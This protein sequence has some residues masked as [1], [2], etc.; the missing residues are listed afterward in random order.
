MSDGS[1]TMTD[2]DQLGRRARSRAT[3]RRCAVAGAADATALEAVFH[4]QRR[5][6]A[7]PV[8]AGEPAGI[9]ALLGTL[10]FADEPHTI[11]A[12]PATGNPAATAVELVRAGRADFVLK[13]RLATRDLLRPV[14]DRTSG[15]N[16]H[17]FVTHL[18][19][20]RLA[21]YHKL[22]A[23]SDSAVIPHPTLADK[24]RIVAV[25]VAALRRLGLR[26]PVVGVL[27]AV[28]TVSERMPETVHADQLRRAGERG[29]FGDAVV[30]GPISYDLA[31]SR[32]SAVTK[33][34]DA[35]HAGDVDMLLVPEMVTGNV[36]SKIWNADPANLLAGCLV[37]TRAPVALTSR[38]APLAEKLH[39]ILLCSLLS[40]PTP[41][42][43]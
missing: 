37:G 34:Y 11:V 25:C 22:L 20:M 1:R 26:R 33:G 15:L 2:F 28:E 24:H 31:T 14:L 4:A 17:G 43:R 19:L 21:G 41:E 32:E 40:E 30:V 16:D 36:M 29:E 35:P 27:C 42:V 7:T 12:C 5:G 18:G 23:M 3:P 8:L 9:R 13:G 10:G 38:S 6:W 39:S